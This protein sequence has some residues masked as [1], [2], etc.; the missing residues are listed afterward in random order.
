MGNFEVKTWPAEQSLSRLGLME[1]KLGMSY[2]V[3]TQDCGLVYELRA[4]HVAA[5]EVRGG[6]T[7]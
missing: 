5:S 1:A 7:G 2:S 6:Q 3:V 4:G